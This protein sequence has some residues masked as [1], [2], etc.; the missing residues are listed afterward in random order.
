MIALT[1][2]NSEQGGNSEWSSSSLLD[3]IGKRAS[4]FTPSMLEISL[5]DDDVFGLWCFS[6]FS[7]A[8]P[9]ISVNF[10]VQEAKND[11]ISPKC[12]GGK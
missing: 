12:S 11:E 10:D 7:E 9:E 8:R 4:G 5:S 2:G 3:L 1:S 6:G